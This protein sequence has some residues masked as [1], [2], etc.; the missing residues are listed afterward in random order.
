MLRFYAEGHPNLLGTHK[1]TLEFTKHS[2]LTL[3][4]NCIVGVNANFDLD[5]IIQFI[6]KCKNNDITITIIPIISEKINFSE[7]N[8]F[9]QRISAKLNRDFNCKDELV[10]RKSDFLSERTFA[11]KSDKGS[12][13]I[14]RTLI[15]FLK[16]KKN[17]VMVVFKNRK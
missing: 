2:D 4:G 7:K 11:I 12:L 3:K 9:F 13:D 6:K 17:K 16:E 5:K 14:N 1:T 8:P 15:N 10:I